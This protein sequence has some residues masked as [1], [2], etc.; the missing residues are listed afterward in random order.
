MP[1]VSNDACQWRALIARAEARLARTQVTLTEAVRAEHRALVTLDDAHARLR[2]VECAVREGHDALHLRTRTLVEHELR[3]YDI[4]QL[5]FDETRLARLHAT[6]IAAVTAAV[7]QHD[8]TKRAVLAA[9]R[10]H[11]SLIRQREKYRFAAATAASH[12][13]DKDDC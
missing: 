1:S 8:E 2:T 10:A 12:S 5:R 11:A 3:R 7:R 9:R 13:D 4:E 6:A